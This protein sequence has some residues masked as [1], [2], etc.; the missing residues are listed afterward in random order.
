[1]FQMGAATTFIGQTNHNEVHVAKFFCHLHLRNNASSTSTNATT[2]LT[3]NEARL[4][5]VP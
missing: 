3:Y 2:L 1:M 5:L 4:G